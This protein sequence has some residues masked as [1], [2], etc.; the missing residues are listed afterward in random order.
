MVYLSQQ[1]FG[2]INRFQEAGGV[3]HLSLFEEF[4]GSVDDQRALILQH[5][6]RL[7][8]PATVDDAEF[9]AQ[10][11]PSLLDESSFLGN[12]YDPKA[13]KLVACG[14]WDIPGGGRIS[15]PTVEQMA[16]LN[17]GAG[18]FSP[19]DPGE[20]GQ[21]AYAFYQTPYGLWEKGAALQELFDKLWG[22]LSPSGTEREYFDWSTP[23]LKNHFNGY[24]EAGAEWWGM[25][26]FTIRN[27]TQARLWVMSA[28][29]T[30]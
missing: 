20:R 26:L 24:F 12:W 19:P 23:D 10:L 22:I 5:F 18:G 28:S 14:D 9:L 1:I 30:D 4:A 17:I 8:T 2:T 7:D 16:K 25:F 3:L 27:V 29:T 13:R 21:F 6:T 15:S 11:R